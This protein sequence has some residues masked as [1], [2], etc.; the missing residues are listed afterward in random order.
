MTLTRDFK[1]TVRA[2]VERDPAFRQALLQEA[3]Q[4]LLEGDAASG[5]M[6]LRDYINATIGFEALAELTHT[7]AKSL[8]RMF[9]PKGN[10][11]AGNL[12]S[13]I[14]ALQDR[15]GVHLEVRAVTKA[16]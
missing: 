6:V 11:T 10:P 4:A 13:V 15:T 16:A 5:R 7:P 1:A 3:V 9:G 8:M 14:G 2:R 12:F